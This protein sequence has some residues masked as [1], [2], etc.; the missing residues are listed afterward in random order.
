[1]SNDYDPLLQ[2]SCIGATGGS[3]AILSTDAIKGLNGT[4]YKKALVDALG[5]LRTELEK[6]PS[7]VR[8]K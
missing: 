5:N 2:H 4:E 3:G 6:K 8:M 7:L 1:M